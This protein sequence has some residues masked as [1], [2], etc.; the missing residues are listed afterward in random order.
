MP[1]AL[2]EDMV[3]QTMET[4]NLRENNN[5][6]LFRDFWKKVAIVSNTMEFNWMSIQPWM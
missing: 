5:G 3:I 4:G 2:V 1:S 6:K